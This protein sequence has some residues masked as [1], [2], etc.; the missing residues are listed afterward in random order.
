VSNF[1]WL[2]ALLIVVTV[3][4][5]ALPSPG[6]STGPDVGK[7]VVAEHGVV[8]SGNPYASEAGVEILQQGGNAVDAAVATALALGVTEPIMSG[9][10]AGG[11]MLYYDAATHQV[12]YI[13][14]YSEAGS[15]PPVGLR[16]LR[17]SITTRG[18]AIPGA[19]AGLLGAQARYGKLTRAQVFAPAIRLAEEGYIANSLLEREVRADSLKVSRYEGARHIFLP[20]GHPI[21]A[22]DR[23]IQPE[24]AATMRAL[25]A[26]GPDLFYKGRIGDDIVRVLRDGGS[27]ITREDFASYQAR[28]KRP[29]CTTYHGRIVLSAPAPQ[30]GMEVLETLNLLAP[31]DLPALGLPSRSPA[32]FRVLAGAMRVAVADRNAYVGDPQRVAVPEAG[33]SAPAFAATRR[34]LVEAPITGRLA[35]GDP[36]PD[37]REAPP[38]GCALYDPAPPSSLPHAAA[39]GAPGDGELAETTH[40]SVV[41]ADG[42][43]VSVTN[44]LG[45]GFGTGTWV[46]GV[47]FNS[48]MF[49]F[50]RNDSGPNAWG[51]HHVPASTIAPT[52]VLKDGAV[53]M[54]VG[55]PGSAAIPPAIVGTIVYGLDYGLDPLAALR[56]PRMVPT[57]GRALR[58][59]DGFA[60]AVDSVA[61]H[62]GYVVT[63]GPPVDM[64]YGGVTVIQR[65]AGR[66]VGAADP[67]RDGEVRGY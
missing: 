24:L 31:Y 33:L 3:T 32:A 53:Q 18:V 47:F 9:L 8:A 41:D 2:P 67:R 30:S 11:G 6:R 29:L 39:L 28:D 49:N 50:A 66:W 55:C 45:L 21:R 59:E 43:A 64:A 65:I 37:D 61:E 60:P 15:A 14:F 5:C 34:A 48:A 63:S 27:T 42:D 58:L 57:S 7:R 12:H 25:A 19:V 54:V 20:G 13:D 40:M 52:L 23:V 17:T 10:G 16:E 56:M 46:D 1:R 22:G 35:P 4:G 44:T 62:L 51:P 36:W 26:E 38:D